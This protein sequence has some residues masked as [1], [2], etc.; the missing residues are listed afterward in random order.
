MAGLTSAAWLAVD[1]TGARH[2]AQNG[3]CTQIGND[4]FAWF[5]TTA[6]KSRRNFLELLRAGYDDYV[7]NAEALAY[8]R[9][10]N[11][12]GP[13]IQRLA[14]HPDQHFADH[15]RQLVFRER[16]AVDR[17]R[18]IVGTNDALP[19]RAELRVAVDE[20]ALHRINAFP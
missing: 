4:R 8:M 2:K 11:L 1:D 14:A 5:G 18:W 10:R 7:I 13:V 17:H 15:A 3:F 20:D 12:A 16:R 6:C 9:S 19:H